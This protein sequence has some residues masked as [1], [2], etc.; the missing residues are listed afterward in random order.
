MRE[1]K[2]I[3]FV[4]WIS[5]IS[6]IFI[7]TFFVFITKGFPFTI[8]PYLSI[9]KNIFNLKPQIV[10]I[11]YIIG[12]AEFIV[13]IVGKHYINT[14]FK[15][16][17]ELQKLMIIWGIAEGIAIFGLISS[18]FGNNGTLFPPLGLLSLIAIIYWKPSKNNEKQNGE[19]PYSVE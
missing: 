19:M 8:E 16:L 17:Y 1:N 10:S 18:F 2:A 14:L 9:L 5:F 3:L 13:L 6:T 11:L 12:I 4:L 7:Y 15:S